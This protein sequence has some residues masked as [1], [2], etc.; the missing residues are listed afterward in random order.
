MCVVLEKGKFDSLVGDS[1]SY[2]RAKVLSR[3]RISLGCYE[4]RRTGGG[5]SLGVRG[6]ICSMNAN[7]TSPNFT[8]PYRCFHGGL[9]DA[10]AEAH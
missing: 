3:C 4:Q 9:A 10:I 8:V 1:V 2:T 7:I 5:E 6:R